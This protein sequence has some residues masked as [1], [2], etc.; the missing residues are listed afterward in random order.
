MILENKYFQVYH[1]QDTEFNTPKVNLFFDI[2]LPNVYTS[3]QNLLYGQIYCDLVSDALNE[4]YYDARLSGITFQL[5]VNHTGFAFETC[6][7]SDKILVWVEKV[8]E[9]L[10]SLNVQ[11]ERFDIVKE[12]VEKN[13]VN[14]AKNQPYQHV[15]SL[16]AH[17]Y[18]L[19]KYHS[20]EYLKV[21]PDINL[22]FLKNQ[23][24]PLVFSILKIETFIHGNMTEK[25]ALTAVEKI[26]TF[27]WKNRSPLPS[28][29]YPFERV[30][31]LPKGKD[32]MVQGKEPNLENNNSAIEVLY[33]LDLVNEKLFS[34]ILVFESIIETPFYSQ[35]RT[36]EQIGYLVWSMF[37]YDHNVCSFALLLQSSEKSPKYILGRCESFID[38]FYKTLVEMD[39]KD[40]DQHI[41]S[42]IE[43]RLKKD[44][45]LYE[46]STRFVNQIRSRQFCFDRKERVAKI[47]ATLTKKD[48]IEFYEKYI[49]KDSQERKRL[50][51]QI[52]SKQF[53]EDMMEK[54][55]DSTILV[56]DV[57]EFKNNS[58]VYPG[59]I[60]F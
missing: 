5:S 11:K 43:G 60:K 52:Y 26:E 22:D 14:F 23:Y 53:Y 12:R 21:L 19:K 24:I 57:I 3:P 35:L 38:D 32:V 51:V 33:Q 27:L 20:D 7:Y 46:Q 40:I 10:F 15:R 13:Y 29:L 17:S 45:N 55:S 44:Q 47:L 28:Y 1:K 59:F 25:E 18:F 4:F 58:S 39:E 37:R 34:T 31:Q 2:L 42:A 49:K 9:K 50:I 16:L 54:G 6:G 30:I 48:I 56:S 41:K 8:F 36:Q